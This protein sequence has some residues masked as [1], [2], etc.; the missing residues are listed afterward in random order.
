[1]NG[2]E[3]EI[4]AKCGEGEMRDE[5]ATSNQAPFNQHAHNGGHKDNKAE[6]GSC[7]L[8]GRQKSQIHS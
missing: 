4:N 6:S 2:N 1:M 3:R 5:E 8:S 7:R